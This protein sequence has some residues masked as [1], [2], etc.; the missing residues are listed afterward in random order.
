MLLSF[1]DLVAKPP[2]TNL[3]HV[4]FILYTRTGC[5]LCEDALAVLQQL[6][7]R[8]GFTLQIVDIDTDPSLVDLHG[9]W[10][11]VVAV[12]GKVRLRGQINAVLL[13]RLLRAAAR[14][15]GESV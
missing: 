12:D 11:P 14:R 7:Q 13:E 6:R 15:H 8:H 1:V 9:N 4:H 5:H 3:N 10:V 2:P